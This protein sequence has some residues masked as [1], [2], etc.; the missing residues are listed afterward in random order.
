MSQPLANRLGSA[1]TWK[2]VQLG[3]VKLI[4]LARVFVLGRLLGPSEF[5]LFAVSLVALDFLLKITD[6]GMVPALVQRA[7]PERQHYDAAWTVGLIR[8]GLVGVAVFVAAPFIADL[9]REPRATDLVRVLALRPL[10]DAG[11]S[12][13]VAELTRQLRFRPLTWIQFSEAIVS[14][15]VSIVLVKPLGVWALV[16][17]PIAGALTSLVVSYVV[18]PHR[19]RFSLNTGAMLPLLRYGRWIF[20][21]A[22]VA[23]LGSSLLQLAISRQLGVV[24]LGLYFLACKLAFLPSEV[25]TGL[26]G[27]VAFPLYARLQHDPRQATRAFQL[28]FT[29][30]LAVL[31][32]A[33]LL[34]L[35]LAPALVD[36]V[37]G[38][39][40]QG[41]VPVIRVL[42]WVNVV[43]LLGDAIVPLLKGVGRPSHMTLL[44][45]VQSGLLA[46]LA[47]ELAGRHGAVGAGYAWLVATG[48]SQILGLYLLR[49]ALPHAWAGITPSLSAVV[50]AALAGATAAWGVVRL[51]P[52]PAG[53]AAAIVCGGGVTASA[54]WALDRLLE[55]NLARNLAR[56]F[57]EA[58]TM[59]SLVTGFLRARST[60]PPGGG[61][62]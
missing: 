48:A 31:L 53:L 45:G 6:F 4:F 26:V 28:I 61:T 18:A 36:H 23:T 19:P 35:V 42:A 30:M 29:G 58:A 33:A 37:L 55:L 1:L 52:G 17:G 40:W 38:P 3:G 49:Q 7:G 44:G 60:V 47:W 11:A 46:L 15:A 22:L 27:A 5:G 32:P 51:E 59:W 57:P 12:I 2:L 16:A 54:L 10:L 24:E 8:A 25:A 56:A 14:T 20:A 62:E 9:F 34:L 21:R 50:T 41:T 39:R 43:G 13:G